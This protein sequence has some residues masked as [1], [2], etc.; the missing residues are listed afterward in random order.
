[1]SEHRDSWPETLGK[2]RVRCRLPRHYWLTVKRS[3]TA[4]V[5]AAGG[6]NSQGGLDHGTYRSVV[7]PYHDRVYHEGRVAWAAL[8]LAQPDLYS[9]GDWDSTGTVVYSFDRHFD[10]NPNLLE[11][12]AA[13]VAR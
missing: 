2:E 6:Y 8:V 10:A 9:L 1:M 11:R 7:A 13:S 12:V 5:G 4:P 3:S